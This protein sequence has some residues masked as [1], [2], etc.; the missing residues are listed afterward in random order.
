MYIGVKNPQRKH[1]PQ[2]TFK[3]L[4]NICKQKL[5][6]KKFNNYMIECFRQF[7]E[8]LIIKRI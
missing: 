4:A 8:A 1:N 3:S 7:T 6:E 2:N 5:S